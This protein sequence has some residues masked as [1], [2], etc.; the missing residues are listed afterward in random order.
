MAKRIH[1]RITIVTS[2][3]VIAL[4]LVGVGVSYACGNASIGF[5]IGLGAGVVV[6][7]QTLGWLIL[8]VFDT[9]AVGGGWILASGYALKLVVLAGTALL[10]HNHQL[11]HA[12]AFGAAFIAGIVVVTIVTTVIIMR[13]QIPILDDDGECGDGRFG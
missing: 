3:I 11:Y 1:E 7:A 10:C 13:A 4:G 6:V 8:K 2:A 5:S 9:L 12:S